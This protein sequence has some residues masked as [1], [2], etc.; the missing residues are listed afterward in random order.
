MDIGLPDMSGCECVW[1][2]RQRGV[3]TPI[4]MLTTQDDGDL[5]FEALAAGASG[6]LLKGLLPA[7]LLMAIHEAHNGKAAM[8]AEIAR[9]TA[10][11][12]QKKSEG[13]LSTQEEKILSALSNGDSYRE[14]AEML[15]IT[16]DAVMEQICRIY[17][18]Q[19]DKAKPGL[20]Y[21]TKIQQPPQ[22]V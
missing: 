14:I 18:K 15:M 2:I 6:Y 13:I 11:A 4:L 19:I 20:S 3:R 17:M 1:E 7:E 16:K 10:Q 5:L 21:K 22:R 9:R 8:S 12:F